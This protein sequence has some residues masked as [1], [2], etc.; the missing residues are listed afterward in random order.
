MGYAAFALAVIGFALGAVFRLKI[1][2]LIL[3]LLLVVSVVFCVTRGFSF[4]DT[5][6]MIM[7]AQ[8]IVQSSYFLG[9]VVK[10]V[11]TATYQMRLTL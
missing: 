3:A 7:L 4:L 11:F 1:L 9:L 8:T 6:L 2:L 5:A 10:A